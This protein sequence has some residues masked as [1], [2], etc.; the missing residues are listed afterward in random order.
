MS[1]HA[2]SPLSRA[3]TGTHSLSS[4]SVDGS[5]AA[6]PSPRAGGGAGPS[7]HRELPTDM[8]LMDPPVLSELVA[9]HRESLDWLMK[10]AVDLVR[11][12]K[13]DR[14]AEQVHLDDVY[15]LRFLLAALADH[16]R[17]E[18]EDARH[19][20]LNHV[21]EALK[22]RNANADLL[23]KVSPEYTYE[24]HPSKHSFRVGDLGRMPCIVTQ[25][26]KIDQNQLAASLSPEEIANIDTLEREALRKLL[27]RKSRVADRYLKYVRVVDYEGFDAGAVN[28]SVMAAWD[29]SSKEDEVHF[30]DIKLVSISVNRGRAAQSPAGFFSHFAGRSARDQATQFQCRGTDLAHGSL[31]E[32][33]FMRTVLTA[34]AC[35]PRELGGEWAGSRET[36]FSGSLS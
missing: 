11:V 27:D 13:L 19:Q 36:T 15:L 32:C 18:K 28:K 26:G 6:A 4:S 9:E 24:C 16:K 34:A 17:S 30:P 1:F 23:A 25:F 5:R 2:S 33:P 8:E 35:L 12:G 10:R 14:V 20:A 29:R 22:W 7:A 3:L 21:Y 31:S